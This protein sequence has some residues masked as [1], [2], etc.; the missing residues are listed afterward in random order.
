MDET[1]AQNI[2]NPFFTTKD[3]GVG[4]GLALTR[5]IIEDHR[6]T[7]VALSEKSKGTTFTVLLPVVK[8]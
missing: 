5:K 3:K 8:F 7:I 4:L 2:F 1:T 6:G